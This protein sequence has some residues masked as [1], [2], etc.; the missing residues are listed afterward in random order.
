MSDDNHYVTLRLDKQTLME[1][2]AIA[3]S[4]DDL[5]ADALVA[6]VN[7]KLLEQVVKELGYESDPNVQELLEKAR[8]RYTAQPVTLY[9]GPEG[10]EYSTGSKSGSGGPPSEGGDGARADP[11]G[12]L[13]EYIVGCEERGA[14]EGF[15]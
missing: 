1:L 14:R 10:I 7:P 5:G 2:K 6:D 3:E 9:V 8:N 15:R 12:A 13:R 4:D 11:V